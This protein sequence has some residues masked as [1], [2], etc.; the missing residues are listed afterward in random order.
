MSALFAENRNPAGGIAIA[1]CESNFLDGLAALEC[2]ECD[3]SDIHGYL[4]SVGA[5]VRSQQY[6]PTAAD[7]TSRPRT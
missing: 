1:E 4:D 6:Q 7:Q 2:E 5:D 3:D